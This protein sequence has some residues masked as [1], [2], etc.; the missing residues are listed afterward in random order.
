MPN[1][2]GNI[3]NLETLRKKGPVV[4]AF[5]RGGWC[6][7]CN[8]ELRAYQSMLPETKALGATLIAITP[9]NPDES[10][11]TSE[12]HNLEFEV[13]TDDKSLYAKELGITFTINKEIIPIYQKFGVD[14]E[15]HNGK[16]QFEVPLASTFI[17]DTDGTIAFSFVKA[18]YTFRAEP[19]AIVEVLKSL[20]K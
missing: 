7:Y 5:Y 20:K 18:D 8:L 16:G 2:L 1:H 3:V 12:R 10:L 6:P 17:I 13:L 4:I 19:T 14:I 11:S 15:K 9:E